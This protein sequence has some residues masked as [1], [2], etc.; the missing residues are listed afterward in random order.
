MNLSTAI[1]ALNGVSPNNYPH[2]LH[3]A[4][5]QSSLSLHHFLPL[6]ITLVFSI[7]TFR[8]FSSIH[9]FHCRTFS[10]SSSLLCAT[11]TRLSAYSI[12]HGNPSFTPRVTTSITATKSSGQ[13]VPSL[14][15]GGGLASGR[16]SGHKNLCL[17]IPMTL[18][19][20]MSM[21]F[22][23]QLPINSVARFQ[24]H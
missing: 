6:L 14:D 8:P 24:F 1:S 20:T 2:T 18:K 3:M 21:T 16:A 12:S 4:I 10:L 9:S 22:I 19:Q 13:P 17:I 11:R 15:K 23:Q 7:F 5:F